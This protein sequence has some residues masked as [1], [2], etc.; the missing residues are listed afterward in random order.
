MFFSIRAFFTIKQLMSKLPR[1]FN[2]FT[3]Y[4]S[5]ALRAY[6]SKLFRIKCCVH[7][8]ICFRLHF[9]V[10][11]CSAH[12]SLFVLI[13]PVCVCVPSSLPVSSQGPI[14]LLWGPLLHGASAWFMG[15]G[16]PQ[17]LSH[18]HRFTSH[19]SPKNT[20]HTSQLPPL[21]HRHSSSAEMLYFSE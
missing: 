10:C 1:L 12:K 17:L 9:Q 20:P 16:Q 5:C 19:T 6:K 8:H 3:S 15:A 4:V 14:W 21:S 11:I 7:V 13:L 2:C 18:F